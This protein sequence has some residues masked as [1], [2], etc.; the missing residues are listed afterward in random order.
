MARKDLSDSESLAAL[1][2]VG[3]AEAHVRAARREE[4]PAVIASLR[5]LQA[6]TEKSGRFSDLLEKRLALGTML[7]RA[8]KPAGRL[9]LAALEEDA[10]ARGFTRIAREAGRQLRAAR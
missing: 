7:L 1:P 3:V 2:I 5:A 10:G 9:Q 4:L 8:G 6:A